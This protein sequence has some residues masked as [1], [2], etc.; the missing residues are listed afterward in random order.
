MK[1]ILQM[2][3][4]LG[5]TV[6]PSTVSAYKKTSETSSK[7]QDFIQMWN[8]Y[9]YFRYDMSDS[10]TNFVKKNLKSIIKDNM[11]EEPLFNNIY[12]NANINFVSLKND[13]LKVSFENK[14]NSNIFNYSFTKEFTLIL[15]NY[16]NIDKFVNNAQKY[17]ELNPIIL[18]KA[19]YIQIELESVIKDK[20]QSFIDWYSHELIYLNNVT[21]FFD[22]L[23]FDS[24]DLNLKSN[25]KL[26]ADFLCSTELQ[27]Y[28]KRSINNI[29]KSQ[30]KKILFSSDINI[31]KNNISNWIAKYTYLNVYD[32][33]I[34]DFYNVE[35]FDYKKG[36]VTI[37]LNDNYFTKSILITLEK[38]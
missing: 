2:V 7:Y 38:K 25:N 19:K 11:E 23:D 9:L 22:F 15:F 31:L 35:S 27:F 18:D 8:D 26:R 33:N 10:E 37:S 24:I 36:I 6:T 14:K 29:L 17:L 5:L 4:A 20:Y 3:L 21:E 32:K 34:I 28:F 12:K 30:N 1:K 16:D 13:V